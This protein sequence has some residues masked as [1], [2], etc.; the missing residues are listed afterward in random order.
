MKVVGLWSG[1]DTSFCVLDDGKPIIHTELER[2]IREKEPKGDS[3]K[4]FLDNYDSDDYDAVAIVEPH[5]KMGSLDVWGSFPK[6]INLCVIGHHEAHAA[7]AFYSSNIKRALIVT[8]DGGGIEGGQE[9]ATTFWVGNDRTITCMRVIP[10][11]QINV[12]GLWT[13]VTRYIFRYQ[14]GWPKGHQAGTVMA[15]AALGQTDKYKADFECMLNQNLIPA[16]MKPANQPIG[17]YTGNDPVHPY[18]HPWTAIADRSD[19]DKFDLARGLQLATEDKIREI[20]QMAIDSVSGEYD[21]L[22][23]AGGVALNSVAMG[24]IQSWFPQFKQVFIPPVPY[25]GGLTLGAAQFVTHHVKDK[26]RVQWDYCFPPYLGAKYSAQDALQAFLDV[27]DPTLELV[28]WTDDDAINMVL[29]QGIVSI[30]EGRAE[31]GRRALG[32][33]SIVAD[34]RTKEMKD[35]VN[36]NVKHRQWFRPFAPSILREAIGEVFIDPKDSPYMSFVS[37]FKPEWAEKVPAVVH[38][39]GTARM[40]TVDKKMS[41]WWHGFIS[42]FRDATGVPLLLNTSFNDCEPICETPAHA[43]KC[44][45]GTAIDALYFPDFGFAICKKTT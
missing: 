7:H 42:K 35:K 28:K 41:P 23:L 17:A 15:L 4:F 3:I 40:Q 29:D 45:Q 33:R 5:A 18:L 27:N 20:I 44:F 30:F 34:P 16:S 38:F 22:C 26:P 39:D 24:K 19:Q 37:T 11:S 31:S 12:G 14:N 13:R 43:V 10:M 36:H 2:H 6:Q 25:D 9:T 21:A 32:S 1:H 8:I